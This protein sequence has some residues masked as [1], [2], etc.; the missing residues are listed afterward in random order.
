[1]TS[2]QIERVGTPIPEPKFV[3]DEGQLAVYREHWNPTGHKLTTWEA[4]RAY[5]EAT[6]E[7][8]LE[9]GSAILRETRTSTSSPSP[10]Y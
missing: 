4:T 8:A 2:E 10:L 9:Y 1:M 3:R 7:E 6:I 5:G